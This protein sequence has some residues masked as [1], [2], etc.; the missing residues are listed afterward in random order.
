MENKKN[1][2]ALLS[3]SAIGS[4]GLLKLS[5]SKMDPYTR[6]TIG[7][8]VGTG[9]ILSQNPLIHYIGIGVG[10]AG[11]LQALDFKKGGS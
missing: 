5:H 8:A 4:Y 2:I 11:F 3:L 6:A 7:I 10:I 1:K 9:M